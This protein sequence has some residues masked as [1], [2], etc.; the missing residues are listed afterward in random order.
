MEKQN[1]LQTLFMD[2]Q[3]LL[4]LSRQ[5]AMPLLFPAVCF[6]PSAYDETIQKGQKVSLVYGV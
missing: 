6:P 5:I 4:H 2:D 1:F 3:A